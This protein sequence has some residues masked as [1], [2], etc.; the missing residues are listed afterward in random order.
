MKSVEKIWAE[1]SA[2][3]STELSEEVKVELALVDDINAA[4]QRSWDLIESQSEA[5]EIEKKVKRGIAEAEEALKMAEDAIAKAKE[6]GA[7]DIEAMMAKKVNEA[8]GR[9]SQGQRFIKAVS[10]L[11]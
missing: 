6:L 4:L 3:V 5:I 11:I 9:I 7:R 1:L 2:K 10:A 8:K